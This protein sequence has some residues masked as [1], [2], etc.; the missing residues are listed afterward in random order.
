ML[1]AEIAG[2]FVFRRERFEAVVEKL[3]SI[4]C[5]R[6]GTNNIVVQP[7]FSAAHDAE[8]HENTE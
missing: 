1:A 6:C 4:K 3:V 8:Q 5:H 2:V 7:A